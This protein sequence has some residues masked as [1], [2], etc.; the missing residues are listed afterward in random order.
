MIERKCQNKKCG[1]SFLARLIDVNRG[2]A[3]F[4]SKSCKAIVQEKNTGQYTHFRNYL[5][6]HDYDGDGMAINYKE[7]VLAVYPEA[8]VVKTIN[9]YLNLYTSNNLFQKAYEPSTLFC[10]VDIFQSLELLEKYEQLLWKKAWD[11][12]QKICLE[13]L[14]L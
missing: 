10:H 4:C 12:I 7:L 14:S 6:D 5:G 11:K 9:S 2:W 8:N 3:K 13:R 1:I